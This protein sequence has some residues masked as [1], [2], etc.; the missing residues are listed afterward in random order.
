VA[1]FGSL[2]VVTAGIEPVSLDLA[3]AHLRLDADDNPVLLTHY[4]SAARAWAEDYLGR[5]IAQTQYR[6]TLTSEPPTGAYP[7]VALPFPVQIYPLWYPWPTVLQHPNNLPRSPVISVDEVAYGMWGA[8]D[9]VVDP[10]NYQLDLATARVRISP[11]AVPPTNDHLSFLFTA[12]YD[13]SGATAP[14]HMIGGI[15]ILLGYLYENRGDV[16]GEFAGDMPIAA[17]RMLGPQRRITFG[18]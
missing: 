8:D 12:G 18:G 11:G 3:R 13:A 2:Q 7:Y 4:I 16:V 5:T 15:L 1:S 10:S 9:T 17:M 14:P 6:Y